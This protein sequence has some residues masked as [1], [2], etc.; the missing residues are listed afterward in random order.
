MSDQSKKTILVAGASGAI[1]R[2]LCR[3]LVD[4]GYAVFGTTRSPDKLAALRAIGIEPVVADVFDQQRLRSVVAEIRPEIIIHQL[5]DLPP[6]L[7][8]AQMAEASIRNA[9]IREVG[10]RNLIAAAVAAQVKR[11]IAQSIAFAYA[12]G[13]M[14]Y[15]EAAPLNIDASDRAGLTA[16]GV[17]SLEQQ[18]LAAALD[19]IILRYGKFYGPG[20]GF[21]QPASG[22]P[23][24]VDAAADAAR[25]AVTRGASGIYNIAEEDGTVSSRKAARDLGWRADFRSAAPE[26]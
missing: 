13:S 16:R 14:P 15:D 9:H 4:D 22:G 5:T 18:V 25:R 10:T 26:R 1:G 2:R 11:M 20:T 7:N 3:L 19:G 8:P 21:E 23:V 24:H 17:A 12:P 6:G